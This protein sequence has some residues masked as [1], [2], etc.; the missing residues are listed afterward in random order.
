MISTTSWA[1]ELTINDLRALDPSVDEQLIDAGYTEDPSDLIIEVTET[2]SPRNSNTGKFEIEIKA[3]NPGKNL[4][5]A[6]AVLSSVYIKGG[7]F[8]YLRYNPLKDKINY[9]IDLSINGTHEFQNVALSF[10]PHIGR[11]GLFAG[12]GGQ[13]MQIKTDLL[14]TT[15]A[16]KVY[17]GGPEIGWQK[18]WGRNRRVVTS[19]KYSATIA[20]HN[21]K[22]Y[23]MREARLSVGL[24]L[25]RK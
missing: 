22:Y 19:L 12:V 21:Y 7:Q 5:I 15:P 18:E 14:P 24:V 3:T 13:A 17:G 6:G 8:S 25:I 9:H 1:T 16:I 10:D 2:N 4:W 11:W 20:Y 23:M